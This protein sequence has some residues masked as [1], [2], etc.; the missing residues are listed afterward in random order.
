MALQPALAGSGCT[1]AKAVAVSTLQPPPSVRNRRQMTAKPLHCSI[2]QDATAAQHRARSHHSAASDKKHSS[3]ASGKKPPP[4][5]IGPKR[6][7]S[8]ASG[9]TPPPRSIWQRSHRRAASGKAPPPCSIGQRSHCCAA[10]GKTPQP[11]SIG[12]EATA[13]QH[14]ARSHSSAVSDQQ[15]STLTLSRSS[16]VFP[17]QSQV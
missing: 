12:Q 14:Q 11:R 16:S 10:S 15:H 5:H 3:I 9:K 17:L 8:S 1:T 13:A 4:R 7:L 6:H 2:G